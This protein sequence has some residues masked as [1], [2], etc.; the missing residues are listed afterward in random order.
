MVKFIKTCILVIFIVFLPKILMSSQTDSYSI[1]KIDTTLYKYISINEGNQYILFISNQ[2]CLGCNV[3]KLSMILKSLKHCSSN[4]NTTIVLEVENT[5]DGMYLKNKFKDID[6]LIELESNNSSNI[7]DS[8]ITLVS[9]N[10]NFPK[11]QIYKFENLNAVLQGI[12]YIV[13][14]ISFPDT[15]SRII[16]PENTYL[17]NPQIIFSSDN[18]IIISDSRSNCI[19]TYS[20]PQKRI[21]SIL[22]I[23]SVYQHIRTREPICD[24]LLNIGVMFPEEILSV[25]YISD[26]LYNIFYSVTADSFSYKNLK[27]I[28]TQ[29]HPSMF[30]YNTI[31]NSLEK[32]FPQFSYYAVYKSLNR[33]YFVMEKPS[34]IESDSNCLFYSTDENYNNVEILLNTYIAD[35]ITNVN[36]IW[37]KIDLFAFFNK[38]SYG[39]LQK[40]ELMFYWISNSK[41]NTINLKG[42]IAFNNN[43]SILDLRLIDNNLIIILKDDSN[44]YIQ[45]YSLNNNMLLSEKIYDNSLKD[46]IIDSKTIEIKDNEILLFNRRKTS[47]WSI[48]S[49]SL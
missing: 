14:A 35:S 5:G 2:N 29:V 25:F 28:N 4:S 44:Y 41:L 43:Y 13:Q 40:S 48:D 46:K 23:P 11:P 45:K 20:K 3:L 17:T 7:F 6:S 32:H 24:S 30:N 38:D 1:E 47:R 26:I 33:Y 8:N 37:D 42:R 34:C 9:L 27:N 18:S 21:V 31:H 16:E 36:N 12:N 22:N 10:K 49:I 19:L 15:R 39:F